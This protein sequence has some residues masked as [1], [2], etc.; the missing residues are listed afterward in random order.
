[1]PRRSSTIGMAPPP[2]RGAGPA[3]GR[4]AGAVAGLRRPGVAGLRRR[5]AG[6]RRRP[7]PRWPRP[8]LSR[9]WRGCRAADRDRGGHHAGD[10]VG[11]D[12]C[13]GRAPWRSLPFVA[14]ARVSISLAE[15]WRPLAAAASPLP[16]PRGD[17]AHRRSRALPRPV[18]PAAAARTAGST[19]PAPSRVA[20]SAS[21]G[22][23]RSPRPRPV[24]RDR[25]PDAWQCRLM[26]CSSPMVRARGAPARLDHP[27][28]ADRLQPIAG[29]LQ[30]SNSRVARSPPARSE[31]TASAAPRRRLA[32]LFS[33]A[34]GRPA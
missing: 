26:R 2:R 7:S 3:G 14:G 30:A 22:P 27:H 17:R 6:L 9:D 13:A 5:A 21:P 16:S 34:P 12:P 33:R 18:P 31:A 4:P 8:R 23:L 24:S 20:G 29:R 19:R 10:R 1:M 28:Q 15:R 25:R 32:A 11:A